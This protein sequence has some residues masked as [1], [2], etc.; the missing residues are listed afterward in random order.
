MGAYLE[1]LAVLLGTIVE[2]LFLVVPSLFVNEY[3][4]FIVGIIVS[5]DILA[6]LKIL[7]NI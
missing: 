2:V 3:I 1:V 7:M 4:K 6:L 5:I